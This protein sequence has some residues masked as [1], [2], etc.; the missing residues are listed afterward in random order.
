MLEVYVDDLWHT[1]SIEVFLL[2]E[3]IAWFKDVV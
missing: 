2:T 3:L 1:V